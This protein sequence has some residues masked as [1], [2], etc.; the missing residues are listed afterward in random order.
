MKNLLLCLLTVGLLTACSSKNDEPSAN[1]EVS[2]DL[3]K[4]KDAIKD[5]FADAEKG[6]KEGAEAT[7]EK[8]SE[9]GDAIKEKVEDAKDAITDD[10]AQIKVEL[11]K[12]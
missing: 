3:D 2:V 7:K 11:K 1:A 9:A 12:D 8:L 5:T 4:T 10:K 6:I